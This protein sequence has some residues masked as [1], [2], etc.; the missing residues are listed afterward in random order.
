[1][2]GSDD[3]VRN[4]LTHSLEVAQ[5]GRELAAGLGCDPNLVDAACLAHDLGHPP[6]GHFGETVLNEAADD[7]GGFE[8]NAQTFRLLT[9]L[10]A[11]RWDAEGNTL[12][13]NLTRAALDAATKYPW[14]RGAREGTHK[15]GVYAD[16]LSAFE[17][18]RQDAPPRTCLEAQV[19]DWADDVAY[20]VHDLEDG[21]AAGAI[22]PAA[23]RDADEQAQIVSV[24]QARYARDLDKDTLAEAIANVVEHDVPAAH[25]GSRRDLGDLK[26][27]TSTLVGRFAAGP[28]RATRE[29]FGTGPLTRYTAELIVPTDVRAQV[30]VLKAAAA[31]FI[32]LTDAR[33]TLLASQ[34]EAL[35]SVLEYFSVDPA[36]LDGEFQDDYR[37]A[38]SDAFARRVIV[39]QVASLT[40]G[41]AWRLAGRSSD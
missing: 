4:R 35:L 17:F 15:F 11:K 22:R 33:A 30:A 36:R 2:A 29:R 32:M 26:N 34:K 39:D 6:F 31:H 25:T 41:R 9:R 12:G 16:D 24:A 37:Q 19:M 14:P 21:I 40:D 38:E 13:L 7:I 27:M 23:L 5:I 28:E 3:F 18:A 1:M 10:E 8:G 20:S